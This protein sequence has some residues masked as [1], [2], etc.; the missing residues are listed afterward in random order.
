MLAEA[1]FL[2][3]FKSLT[4]FYAKTLSAE[5][6]TEWYE[7]CKQLDAPTLQ[8]AVKLCRHNERLFPTPKIL[9]DHAE[10]VKTDQRRQWKYD[11]MRDAQRVVSGK[12]NGK[13]GT[14]GPAYVTEAKELFRKALFAELKGF[15]LAEAMYAMA[16][17][18]PGKGW[19]KNAEDVLRKWQLAN[20]QAP[21]T[22]ERPARANTA[23]N[24]MCCWSDK[25]WGPCHE[26]GTVSPS[27]TG[28]DANGNWQVYCTEH[29]GRL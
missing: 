3:A 26:I 10:I 1:D 7:C 23:R 17:K 4:A 21:F 16:E 25:N 14:Y 28:P 19:A 6:V 22:D 2:P 12:V 27:T 8:G 24:T 11:E 15:E 18:Y 13:V 9:L 29:F 5:Q 20:G